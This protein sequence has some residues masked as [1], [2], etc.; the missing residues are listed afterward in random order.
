MECGISEGCQLFYLRSRCFSDKIICY[1]VA[2][3]ANG[4]KGRQNGENIVRIRRYFDCRTNRFLEEEK[5]HV[6]KRG[7]IGLRRKR[8]HTIPKTNGVFVSRESKANSEGEKISRI[9]V[10]HGPIVVSYSEAR[11]ITS[12]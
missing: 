11:F 2:T 12:L 7:F 3:L 5:V 9:L 1:L 8:P 6:E 10:A 4:E